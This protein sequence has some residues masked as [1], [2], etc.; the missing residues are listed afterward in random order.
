[1]EISKC[2]YRINCEMGGCNKRANYTIM[3]NKYGVRGCLHICENCLKQ[4]AELAN[5]LP[6]ALGGSGSAESAKLRPNTA[7]ASAATKVKAKSSRS[8]KGTLSEAHK[9]V[10]PAKE[11]NGGV[12][13]EVCDG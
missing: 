1:M 2:K 6:E 11:D 3:P 13:S 8:V 10:A 12:N 4:L 7:S 5:S 9:D